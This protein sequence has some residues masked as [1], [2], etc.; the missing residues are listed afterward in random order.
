MSNKNAIGTN[1]CYPLKIFFHKSQEYYK[2]VPD[3]CDTDSDGKSQQIERKFEKFIKYILYKI[4][5][6]INFHS[7]FTF[8]QSHNR[9]RAT[10]TRNDR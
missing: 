6:D 3:T 1:L 5:H 8:F 10:S 4:H 9:E 7:T 2:M